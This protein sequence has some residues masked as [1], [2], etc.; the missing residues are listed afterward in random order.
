MIQKH[1]EISLV[2]N[3]NNLLNVTAIS[4]V[5]IG[6]VTYVRIDAYTNTSFA[7]GVWTTIATGYPKP[8]ANLY[9]QTPNA[10]LRVNM[11]GTLAVSGADCNVAIDI[12][13][14]YPAL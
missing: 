10:K 6:K 9:F 8:E 13:V 12:M 14:S 3:I 11:D 2:E 4:C 1:H 7:Y 5:A